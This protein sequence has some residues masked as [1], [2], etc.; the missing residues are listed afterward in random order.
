LRIVINTL[1]LVEGEAGVSRADLFSS[2]L[3]WLA[4]TTSRP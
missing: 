4:K 3:T 2:Y 1:G